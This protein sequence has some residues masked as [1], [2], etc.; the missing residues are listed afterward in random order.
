LLELVEEHRNARDRGRQSRARKWVSEFIRRIRNRLPDTSTA[1]VTA[2]AAA[3]SAAQPSCLQVN[4][5]VPLE[6]VLRL[7]SQSLCLVSLLS[8]EFDCSL[9]GLL[10]VENYSL[11]C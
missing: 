6:E 1:P 3:A 10:F 5:H 11:R 8:F 9:V 7:R 4:L 2:A